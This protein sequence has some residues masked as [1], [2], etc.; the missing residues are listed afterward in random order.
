MI[1]ALA[2]I[3][4]V[5]VLTAPLPAAEP[6]LS[7]CEQRMVDAINEYRARYELPPLAVD[8]ILMC[9]ARQR[10]GCFSHNHPR[11]GWPWQHA[12]RCGFAGPATDNLCRSHASP[13]APEEA[14]DGWA[15]SHVGHAEQMRGL[16]KINDEWVDQK[17]NRL[18]VAQRGC[19]SVAV[20]GRKE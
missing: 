13:I 2:I 3:A 4:V 16:M 7:K 18:G 15:Q 14:V 12:K 9:V 1:A 19:D 8:P 20:F 5:T 10:V 6:A 11:Y 17:F